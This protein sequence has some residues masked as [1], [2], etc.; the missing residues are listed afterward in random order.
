MD[1]S[2]FDLLTKTVIAS[3]SRRRLNHLLGGLAV[4]GPV[5]V[6]GSA[7]SRAKKK[8]ITLCHQGQTIKVSKKAKKKHLD[9]GDT[10]GPCSFCASQPDDTFCDGGKCYQGVCSPPPVC[11]AYPESCV[12]NSQCCSG[13]CDGDDLCAIGGLGAACLTD[14]E[15]RSQ[16]CRGY[17]C[18]SGTQEIGMNCRPAGI[19]GGYDEMCRSGTCRCTS[20]VNFTCSCC[21]QTGGV[22]NPNDSRGRDATCCTG[23]CTHFDVTTGVTTCS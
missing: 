16:R 12:S 15:C 9:H 1:G 18:A 13:R 21:S 2:A 11:R 17:H 10:L 6:L 14:T 3:R 20:G 8:K 5:A 19:G 7:E 22:C 23:T 4:A